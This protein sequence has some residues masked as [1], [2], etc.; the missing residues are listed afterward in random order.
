MSGSTVQV[1]RS[2]SSGRRGNLR[3]QLNSQC[4]HHCQRSLQRRVSLLLTTDNC[5]RDSPVCS[6][7]CAIPLARAATNDCVPGASTVD[8]STV[9]PSSVILSSTWYEVAVSGVD[10]LVRGNCPSE[11]E[12]D[13]SRL[14]ATGSIAR[15]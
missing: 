2:S 9:L 6:A 11:T 8:P 3:G 13:S 5:S 14:P 12:P 4:L 7:I 1:S 15:E 10:T